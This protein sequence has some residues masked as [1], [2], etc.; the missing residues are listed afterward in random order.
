[1]VTAVYI[2]N[3]SPTKARRSPYKAWHGRKPAVSHLWVF[4]C[5]AFAKEL[6]HIGK[7]D[8]RSILGVFVGYMEGLKAYRVLDPKTQRVHTTR[9]DV[10]NEGRGW[11][12]DKAVD[13]GSTLTYDDFTVEHVHFVGA[14]GVG[15]SS[16][17]SMPTSAPKSPSTPMS[18]TP[19]P[20]SPATT[21]AAPNPSLTPPQPA[22]PHALAST[23]T[24]PGMSSPAP[25]HV[26]HNPLEFASP[27]TTRS[28]ST[29]IT[30][31]SSCGTV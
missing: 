9:D 23:T 6:G 1:V 7:L 5:L 4:G 20:H 22:M 29:G 31:A 30:M 18:C 28:A 8:D 21:S 27:L 19:T 25:A 3:C 26:E 2:L 13:N 15:S 24:L 12:W 11:A 14:R 16:S 10:F 17:P